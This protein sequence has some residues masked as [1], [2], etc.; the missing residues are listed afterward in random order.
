M[1]WK[2][3]I[4]ATVIVSIFACLVYTWRYPFFD[5]HDRL[6]MT[7]SIDNKY[8]KGIFTTKERAA[9]LNDLLHETQKYAKPDDYLIAY[10]C[11]PMINYLTRTKPYMRSSYPWLYEAETFKA[12]LD[13]GLQETKTLPVVIVQKIKTIGASSN[14]PDSTSEDLSVYQNKNAKRD[15]YMNE[16]LQ[17]HQYE[18]VWDSRYFKLFVP[19]AV[20]KREE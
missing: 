1:Q 10:Q 6:E 4:N 18:E 9:A 2:Q 19:P 12:Q 16:F 11:I 17:A 20:A 14:W 7:S 3:I 13:E 15:A 8:L 5:R